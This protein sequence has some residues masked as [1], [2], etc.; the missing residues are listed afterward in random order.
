MAADYIL[1]FSFLTIAAF[2]AISM[3]DA[4]GAARARQRPT[5]LNYNIPRKTEHGNAA[6]KNY[7]PFNSHRVKINPSD[8]ILSEIASSDVSS[9]HLQT[10]CNR[11]CCMLLGSHLVCVPVIGRHFFHDQLSPLYTNKTIDDR[12]ECQCKN[13]RIGSNE[14]WIRYCRR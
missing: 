5:Y 1:T 6:M 2:Y 11:N 14:K 8:F 4:F 9:G 7:S 13:N 12:F 3:I 10:D